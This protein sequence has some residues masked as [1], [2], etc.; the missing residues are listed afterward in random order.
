MEVAA[1][2]FPIRYVCAFGRDLPDGVVALD[3]CLAPD[4]AAWPEGV[5]RTGAADGHVA[6]VTFETS[7]RGLVPVA[8]SHAQLV[9]GGRGLPELTGG[10]L[11]TIPPA[12]FAGVVLTLLPLLA[13]GRTLHLHHGFDPESFAAQCDGL[14]R[15]TLVLPGPALAPLGA[16][17]M[18]ACADTII[19]LWRSPERLANAPY[20]RGNAEVVDVASFG[21]IGLLHAIRPLDGEPVLRNPKPAVIE[22][23]RTDGGTLAL[24]G[25]MVPAHA[26]PP[27]AELDY[28]PYLAG[29]AVGFVDTG[30][31]CRHDGNTWTITAPPC[32]FTSIGGYRLLARDVESQI[33]HIDAD[34]TV[35]A[36]PHAATGQRL[37]GRSAD[38]ARLASELRARG[39]NPL[40]YGAFRSR[41]ADRAA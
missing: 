41:A 4:A 14:P 10:I 18:L 5:M 17:N 11:T 40:I 30:F 29:D 37:A 20:W 39:V 36:L 21:E 12:S 23:A 25:A 28:E 24:R 8:R 6:V 38:P 3:A 35:L 2:L 9:A 1:E 26:F 34:A 32:G 27:G 7:S 13:A 19:A 31:A 22:A 16:A 33:A 15:A